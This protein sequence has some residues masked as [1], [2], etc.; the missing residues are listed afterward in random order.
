MSSKCVT[1]LRFSSFHN[2]KIFVLL[3]QKTCLCRFAGYRVVTTT[4]AFQ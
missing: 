4:V 1:F 3:P 2:S